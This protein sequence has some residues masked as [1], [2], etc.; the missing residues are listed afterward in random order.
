MTALAACLVLGALPCADGVGPEA[1]RSFGA[2]GAWLTAP[3]LRGEFAE[4]RLRSTRT[5]PFAELAG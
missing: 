3:D 4:A 1:D 5:I 2:A